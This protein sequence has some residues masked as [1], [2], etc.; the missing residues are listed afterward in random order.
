MQPAVA[1]ATHYNE[2]TLPQ[3]VAETTA[4]PAG[5]GCITQQQGGDSAGKQWLVCLLTGQDTSK[6]IEK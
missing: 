5:T 3:G 6:D 1:E 4:E 2:E